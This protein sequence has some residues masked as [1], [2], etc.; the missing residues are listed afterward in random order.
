MVMT[1][2]IPEA[3]SLILAKEQLLEKVKTMNLFTDIFASVV[4]KN[5]GAC[6]HLI[7]VL[8]QNPTLKILQIMAQND[9]PQLIS[10]GARLDVLAEDINGKIYEIE[11]Q[12]QEEPAPARRMR[13]YSSVMDSEFLL[14]G[15]SYDKLPEVYLFYLSENDIWKQGKLIYKI[16]QSLCSDDF[17]APYDNGLHTAFIN[18]SVDDDSDI[19]KLMQ[20]LKTANAGD[21]SQGALSAY[22]NKLKS[23][24]GGK[25]IM[26][27]FEKHFINEGVKKGIQQGN[28]QGMRRFAELT[29][30]LLSLGRTEDLNRAAEDDSYRDKLFKEFAIQ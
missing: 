13:F 6:L 4:F 18:A 19:A 21:T 30:K 11:V 25:I 17:C 7:R 14:K 27:E 23:P 28:Q 9:I 29:K 22:V 1:D 8:M 2:P 24:K 15:A 10:H 20:Y 16:K 26:G 5:K 12:K 3:K